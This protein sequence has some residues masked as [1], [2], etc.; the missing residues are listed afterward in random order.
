[1]GNGEE[2]YW[3]KLV[4]K[5]VFLHYEMK[6]FIT[7]YFETKMGVVRASALR[8]S[9]IASIRLDWP[10]K[11]PWG[12]SRNSHILLGNRTTFDAGNDHFV[13]GQLH[14]SKSAV[15][16]RWSRSVVISRLGFMIYL[17]TSIYWSERVIFPRSLTSAG[18]YR[19]HQS[20]WKTLHLHG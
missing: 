19:A 11:E 18:V 5:Y 10:L 8:L 13:H 12:R 9:G 1:M 4:I 6:F 20:C 2:S 16:V 15:C 3:A 14:N 7:L 17:Y